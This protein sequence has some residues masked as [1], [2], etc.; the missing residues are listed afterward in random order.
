MEEHYTKDS[1]VTPKEV[2]EAE[3]TLNDPSR[4]WFKVMK[5][6]QIFGSSQKAT[7]D[8]RQ[9]CARK[10]LLWWGMYILN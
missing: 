7:L 4:A 1:I 8:Q 3:K 2:C 6:G 5:I 10:A 9:V